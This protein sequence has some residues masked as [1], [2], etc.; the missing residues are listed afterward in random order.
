MKAACEREGRSGGKSKEGG[1][2]YGSRKPRSKEARRKVQNCSTRASFHGGCW[3]NETN[4]TLLWKEVASVIGL[5]FYLFRFFI[6]I[7]SS[8]R[9]ERSLVIVTSCYA[10]SCVIGKK[11]GKKHQSCST[12]KTREAYRGKKKREKPA[13]EYE[14]KEIRED[15]IVRTTEKEFV[16]VFVTYIVVCPIFI[17]LF[18]TLLSFIRA[19][20]VA[21]RNQPVFSASVCLPQSISGS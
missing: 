4:E 12:K 9:L 14:I 10:W 8:H 20:S 17:L 1:G 2:H 21:R 13:K 16:S 7:S 3:E 18:F 5:F 11:V 6:F 19:R 15:A